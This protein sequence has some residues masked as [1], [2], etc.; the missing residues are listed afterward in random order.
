MT[1]L[2]PNVPHE[3]DSG[4]VDVENVLQPGRHRFRLTVFDQA[5]NESGPVFL[6]VTVNEAP[7]R[8]PRGDTRG[9]TRV[10][11]RVLE[12]VVIQPNLGDVLRTRIPRR[13]GG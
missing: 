6:I 1:L 10:D 13:P 7:R 8:D 5:K 9:D 3:T 4:I 2:V 12:R 11:P